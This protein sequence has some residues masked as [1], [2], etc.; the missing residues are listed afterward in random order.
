MVKDNPLAPA[1]TRDIAVTIGRDNSF[2]RARLLV[3]TME[4]Q[5]YWTENV[6]LLE[7]SVDTWLS[8]VR[9]LSETVPE[10][11]VFVSPAW[12]AKWATQRL[13]VEGSG[14]HLSSAKF[15]EFLCRTP[16]WLSWDSDDLDLHIAR[17]LMH[18]P[19]G[20]DGTALLAILRRSGSSEKHA[21]YQLLSPTHP[22]G[23][24]LMYGM[25]LDL[26]RLLNRQGRTADAHWVLDFGRA[27]MPEQFRMR[28][29]AEFSLSA[30]DGGPRRKATRAEIA[31]GFADEQG[32]L[33]N[34]IDFLQRARHLL[35]NT[36][37]IF[38]S[39]DK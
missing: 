29:S 25:L 15:D 24:G 5:A 38:R 32:N 22:D 2:W 18:H 10:K 30:R 31:A 16:F 9:H 13:T 27:H 37:P 8:V 26:A 21:L 1:P 3:H 4:A 23:N 35:P 12:S 39:S 20:G 36:K 14:P 19:N 17:L 34:D 33:K 11:R 6:M 7:D 28:K